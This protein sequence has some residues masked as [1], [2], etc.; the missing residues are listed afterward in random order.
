[1]QEEA[2]M[3]YIKVGEWMTRTVEKD[4]E[5]LRNMNKMII[6]VDRYLR[7]I[8]VTRQTSRIRKTEGFNGSVG[9]GRFSSFGDR[10]QCEHNRKYHQF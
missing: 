7:T 10:Y 8:T 4:E 3:Q 6:R 5:W 1:M 2:V 9:D